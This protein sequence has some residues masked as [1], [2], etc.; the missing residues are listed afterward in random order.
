MHARFVRTALGER[1]S[2]LLVI[3]GCYD[4]DRHATSGGDM[5]TSRWLQAHERVKGLVQVY[6][7][8]TTTRGERRAAST[9]DDR[10][11]EWSALFM[12]MSMPRKRK[13][14]C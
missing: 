9:R 3:V 13:N 4:G 12:E 2:K 8:F 5:K 11:P 1:S 7:R 14:E 10:A 6:A